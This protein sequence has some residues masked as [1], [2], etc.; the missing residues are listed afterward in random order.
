MCIR[1]SSTSSHS[2][3]HSLSPSLFLS[4][5]LSLTL[6]TFSRSLSLPLSLSPSL[7][8]PLSLYSFSSK[9]KYSKEKG[10]SFQRFRRWI[11]TWFWR[12][13]K[14]C[15]VRYYWWGDTPVSYTHLDVYKRQG[16]GCVFMRV[17]VLYYVRWKFT[18]VLSI[19]F[20]LLDFLK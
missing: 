20:Y 17:I 14:R 5:T 3:S 18:V 11:Q 6:P 1:D 16:L 15:E 19:N 12:R 8:T 13:I 2:L 7:F 10:R 9:N 4:L